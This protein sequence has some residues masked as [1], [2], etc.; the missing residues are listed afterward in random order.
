MN[1]LENKLRGVAVAAQVRGNGIAR[2]RL[3]FYQLAVEGLRKD[4]EFSGDTL[5]LAGKT[6]AAS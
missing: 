5:I 1:Q 3:Q 4:A 2:Q 6:I